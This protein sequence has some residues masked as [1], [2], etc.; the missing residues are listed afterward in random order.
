MHFEFGIIDPFLWEDHIFT[1]LVTDYRSSVDLIMQ[2]AST[3]IDLEILKLKEAWEQ[4]A[5][6]KLELREE[7]RQELR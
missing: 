6:D 3:K 2:M 5:L 7:M 1:H 4:Y